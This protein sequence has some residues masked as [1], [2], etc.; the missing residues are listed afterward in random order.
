MVL[1]FWQALGHLKSVAD[2]INRE[3]AKFETRLELLRV[4]D[5][6]VS[7]DLRLVAP[8]RKLVQQ[9]K[10]ELASQ[11]TNKWKER[12]F[13]LFNDVILLASPSL[14]DWLNIFHEGEMWK[15]KAY[16]PLTQAELAQTSDDRSLRLILRKQEFKVRSIHS[17][18]PRIILFFVVP[19]SSFLFSC[20]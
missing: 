16:A 3:K 12:Q 15:L 13:F 10:V 6:F 4:Q 2:Y 5:S 18:S 17:I 20:A 11:K 9:G 1:R 14:L 7:N 19:R 8:H